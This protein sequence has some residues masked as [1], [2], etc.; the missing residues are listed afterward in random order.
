MGVGNKNKQEVPAQ[1]GEAG[2]PTVEVVQVRERGQT[3]DATLQAYKRG[4]A[5]Y[6]AKAYVEAE[7][8]RAKESESGIAALFHGPPGTGKT[9]AAEAIGFDLGTPLKVVSCSQLISKWVGESAKNIETVFKA[10]DKDSSGTIDQDELVTFLLR[11][12]PVHHENY[13]FHRDQVL[14]RAPPVAANRARGLRAE[15]VDPIG[16][17]HADDREGVVVAEAAHLEVLLVQ[18]ESRVGIVAQRAEAMGH[19]N[20]VDRRRG[21]VRERGLLALEA[22]RRR[23]LFRAME[24]LQMFSTGVGRT[25]MVDTPPAPTWVD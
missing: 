22:G 12:F 17:R 15:E 8:E 25:G 19:V 5:A 2:R 3:T 16:H 14:V 4:M 20:D 6:K 18:E 13:A 24:G 23:H 7:L 9:L 1:P 21:D 11:L 10:I